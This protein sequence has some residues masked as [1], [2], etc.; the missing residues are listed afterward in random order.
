MSEDSLERLQRI[1]VRARHRA[2]LEAA[3]RR[4]LKQ[5]RKAK[6]VAED[7]ADRL[8]EKALYRRLLEDFRLDGMRFQFYFTRISKDVDL[9]ELR[10]WIDA[11]IAEETKREMDKKADRPL[12][13]MGDAARSEAGPA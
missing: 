10:A 5:K 2:G 4:A 1:L 3:A 6:T 9:T 12:V 13:R 8:A 7:Y 11:K